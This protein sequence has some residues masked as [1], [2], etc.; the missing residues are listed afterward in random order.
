M[1]NNRLNMKS[2]T[3]SGSGCH[4]ETGFT[5]LEVLVATLILAIALTV[6]LQLFSGGLNQARRAGDYTRA[7]WHARAKMEEMLL[8]QP[9]GNTVDQGQFED[10]Y[11]WATAI[12]PAED[13]SSRP[14]GPRPYSVKVTVSWEVLGRTK[15]V[16]LETIALGVPEE[17]S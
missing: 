13:I 14:E 2:V 8:A 7:V 17:S 10:G 1:N 11:Q 16:A 4:G 9:R 15:Q 12:V 5:L 6:I 3:R